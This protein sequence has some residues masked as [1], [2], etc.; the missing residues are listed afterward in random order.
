[1]TQFEQFFHIEDIKGKTEDEQMKYFSQSIIDFLK[2]KI[3][4]DEIKMPP[5]YETHDSHLFHQMDDL[6]KDNKDN[7]NRIDYL[8]SKLFIEYMVKED[9]Q[10]LINHINS[11]NFNIHD[12]SSDNECM[13]CGQKMNLMSRNWIFKMFYPNIDKSSGKY[14]L[15]YEPVKPCLPDDNMFF[16]IDFKTE[17]LLVT[18][19]FRIDAFNK[20]VNYE[21]HDDKL[22]IGFIKGRI[23]AT[24][25]YA[26]QGFIC[27]SASGGPEVYQHHDEII[28]AIPKENSKRKAIGSVDTSR[29]SICVIEEEKLVEI[30]SRQMSEADAREKIKKYIK[31]ED[32]LELKIN[33]GEYEVTFNEKNFLKD[34]PDDLKTI[35]S[36]RPQPKP[37]S[38]L[39]MK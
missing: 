20:E 31:E 17:K 37:Q 28:F 1:M 26:K 3:R 11:G 23:D 29:W 8:F 6:K 25:H 13:C 10:G 35:F 39:K 4:N 30:L 5:G 24:N 27:I 38:R 9:F 2:V 32:V 21:P 15:K 18:D 14:Q 16:H 19:W 33:A 36:I 12:L 7:F 22:S 34:Y